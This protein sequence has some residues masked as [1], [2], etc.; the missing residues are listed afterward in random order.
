[1]ALQILCA[2]LILL[3]LAAAQ[4]Q[5]AVCVND[6]RFQPLY[7]KAHRDPCRIAES[8]AG[9]CEVQGF[10]IPPLPQG[11]VYFGPSSTEAN[12]CRCN[13]VFYSMLSACAACQNRPWLSWTRYDTQC[14][15]VT[16]TTFPRSLPPGVGVPHY[17]YLDVSVSG[18][19]SL[20]DALN[21]GGVESTAP[22]PSSTSTSTSGTHSGS[23]K[24]G[25]I[26]GGVVG[27][28]VGAALLGG[29]A[30]WWFWYRKRRSS[31]S[32]SR[33]A[34]V[35]N[36][37]STTPTPYPIPISPPPKLYDPHDPTTYPTAHDMQT[38]VPIAPS[39]APMAMVGEQ[40]RPQ[41]TPAGYSGAPE[42]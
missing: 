19:F 24:A 33:L 37:Q 31:A 11:N 27:G 20:D 26:A 40:P 32:Q 12:D 6:P 38:P 13:S 10:N 22:V 41:G 25:A 14:R 3:P 8:L 34:P 30:L 18:N 16:V 42:V 9:V 2:G 35:L 4:Q 36:M 5:Q 17:A 23:N 39:P 21:A 29:L 7:N 28:V 1:M 15:N